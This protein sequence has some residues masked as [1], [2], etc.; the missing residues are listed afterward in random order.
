MKKRKPPYLF[1]F[2]L[3]FGI[4]IKFKRL[5]KNNRLIKLCQIISSGIVIDFDVNDS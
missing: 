5:G 4:N 1:F 2:F 3:S